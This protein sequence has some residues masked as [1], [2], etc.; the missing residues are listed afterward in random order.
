MDGNTGENAGEEVKKEPRDNIDWHLA[1]FQAFQLEFEPYWEHLE[2]RY[3]FSLSREPLEIDIVVVKKENNV[4]IENAIGRIFRKCNIIE[5]KSPGDYLSVE[6]FY[7]VMGYMYIYRSTAAGTE[8]KDITV[9]FIE[10]KHPQSLFKHL[11]EERGFGITEEESGIYRIEGDFVPVQLIETQ[12]ARKETVKYLWA[13]SRK[14][15]A[16]ELGYVMESA[17]REH[18]IDPEGYLQAVLRGNP[19]TLEEVMAMGALTFEEVLDKYGYTNKKELEKQWQE[20]R[21]RLQAE[22]SRWQAEVSQLRAENAELKAKFGGS[23]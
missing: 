17:G 2:Y 18:R 8:L 19:Q 4:I 20:E 7:K 9:T 13:L 22:N 14:L 10:T 1:F 16:E 3:K 23:T 5:F 11:R 21:N 12:K 6:D 15:N